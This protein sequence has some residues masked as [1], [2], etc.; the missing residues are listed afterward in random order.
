MLSRLIHILEHK[1]EDTPLNKHK[2]VSLF[3]GQLDKIF[4]VD[5]WRIGMDLCN[6]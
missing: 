4:L 2:M 6:K 1:Y 5:I 3:Y